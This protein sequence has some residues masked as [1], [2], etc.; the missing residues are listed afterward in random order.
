MLNAQRLGRSDIEDI[1][2]M[3]LKLEEESSKSKI[4]AEAV[5]QL[6]SFKSSLWKNIAGLNF[7]YK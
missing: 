4:A 2:P 1:H 6:K 3:F 7:I 5:H